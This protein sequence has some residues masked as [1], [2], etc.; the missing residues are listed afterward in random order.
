[1]SKVSIEQLTDVL[2]QRI[3]HFSG[4]KPVVRLTLERRHADQGP[5]V[6]YTELR[7]E[8][9]SDLTAVEIRKVFRGLDAIRPLG[10]IKNVFRTHE[11]IYRF[12]PRTAK[13]VGKSG[14]PRTVPGSIN[15]RVWRSKAD[16][17]INFAVSYP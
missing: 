3:A 5:P 14:K 12:V 8:P 15:I 1:L 6:P 7:Y 13:A 16:R 10:S 9:S 11:G 4:Q 2:I 17:T